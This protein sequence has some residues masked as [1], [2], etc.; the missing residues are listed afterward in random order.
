MP[1]QLSGHRDH[2]I[3]SGTPRS[4]A[5]ACTHSTWHGYIRMIIIGV[6]SGGRQATVDCVWRGATGHRP[7]PGPQP[8]QYMPSLTLGVTHPSI[9]G[10]RTMP[11]STRIHV[12]ENCVT[13][14]PGSSI[15][16]TDASPLP[17]R[18]TTVSARIPNCQS[19]SSQSVV[20][21]SVSQL[22]SQ[23]VV[24]R[25]VSP[26]VLSGSRWAVL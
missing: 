4:V 19:V 10:M 20:S 24:S 22:V 16:G 1:A 23:S 13:L 9:R 18:F 21:G 26:P 25:S 7:Q 12:A 11:H 5:C 6:G 3:T 15:D 14:Q 17:G 8:G 2:M